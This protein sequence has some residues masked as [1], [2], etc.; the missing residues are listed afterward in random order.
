[1]YSLGVKVKVSDKRLAIRPS[2]ARIEYDNFKNPERSNIEM[3][4]V[5]NKRREEK[6]G[7][8]L[9]RLKTKVSSTYLRPL[10]HAGLFDAKLQ[11]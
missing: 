5:R 6:V 2:E 3:A 8:G 11:P 9:R 1:M 10:R 4:Q 7:A